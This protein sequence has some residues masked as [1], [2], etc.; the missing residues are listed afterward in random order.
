M[1]PLQLSGIAGAQA[2]LLGNLVLSNSLEESE[3]SKE[4]MR[5]VSLHP[6]GLFSVLKTFINQSHSIFRQLM[7]SPS[8]R[9]RPH[10]ESELGFLI[11]FKPVFFKKMRTEAIF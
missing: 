11:F 4:H 5:A 9:L 10:S 6:L 8:A 3:V 2:K 1:P 7:P